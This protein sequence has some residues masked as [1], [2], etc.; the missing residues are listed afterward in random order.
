MVVENLI[1]DLEIKFIHFET[2]LVLIGKYDEEEKKLYDALQVIVQPLQANDKNT[3][4]QEFRL[5]YRFIPVFFGLTSNNGISTIDLKNAH[6]F[7]LDVKEE[8]KEQYERTIATLKTGLDLS[9]N[10]LDLKKLE[11]KNRNN[12]N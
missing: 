2:G 12:L 6:Y 1:K 8:I 4:S 7:V 9:V 3:I 10:E 11:K 5:E